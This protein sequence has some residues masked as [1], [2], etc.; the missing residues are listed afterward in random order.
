MATKYQDSAEFTEE[1]ELVRQQIEAIQ[2]TMASQRWD[3]HLRATDSK[4]DTRTLSRSAAALGLVN[5]LVDFLDD[6]DLE[7]DR[8]A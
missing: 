5:Q 3:R 4:F 6:F 7:L 2:M 8:A 1:L